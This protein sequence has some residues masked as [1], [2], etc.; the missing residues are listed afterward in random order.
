MFKGTYNT[1][2]TTVNDQELSK[3]RDLGARWW[4]TSGPMAPLHRIQPHRLDYIREQ[5]SLHFE[6][7]PDTVMQGLDVIDVGC[8]GGLVC[9][10]LARLGAHVTGI[11]PETQNIV[12]AATHAEAQ[13]L[14][15]TY[16]A[17][18][19]DQF[20]ATTPAQ[21]FDVVLSLEVVEHV[22]HID[23][24]LQDCFKLL[25]PDGIVI[26]STLNRTAKS[27]A[28]AILGAEY[29]LRWLPIGTHQWSK[30]V[31]PAELTSY[32]VADNLRVVDTTGLVYNPLHRSWAVSKSDLDVNY[33]ITAVRNTR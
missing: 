14:A 13:N 11:D 5:V 20:L 1:V 8:G 6:R 31:T 27:F 7:H 4:D 16:R 10:P 17:Q 19:V 29:V 32:I 15:I 2:Q 24:Y 22:D 23:M 26:L 33:F 3:F 28:L 25:K 21:K 30:F 9:E 18:T 12:A